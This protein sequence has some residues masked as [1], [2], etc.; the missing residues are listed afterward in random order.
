MIYYV[1][2]HDPKNEYS[3]AYDDF[4]DFDDLEDEVVLNLLET[5]IFPLYTRRKDVMAVMPSIEWRISANRTVPW[6]KFISLE[7]FFGKVVSPKGKATIWTGKPQFKEPIEAAFKSLPRSVLLTLACAKDEEPSPKGMDGI[8][9][10]F[11]SAI[12]A[13]LG[14]IE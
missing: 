10:A 13:V 11:R 8:A 1:I 7:Y 3:E 4:V 9:Q 12:V 2:D 6:T 14:D 5:Q